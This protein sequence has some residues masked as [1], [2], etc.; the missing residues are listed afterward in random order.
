MLAQRHGAPPPRGR[1]RRRPAAGS[2][3]RRAGDRDDSLTLLF[4]CCHPALTPVSQIALTLR[5]VGGLTTAEIARALLVPEST[6]GAAHQP[7]QGDGSARAA[8]GSRMPAAGERAARLAAVL[9]VLYLVFNEG[10]TAS[11]GGRRC[12]GPS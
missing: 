6:V 10:Y 11:S 5:A 8:P 9:H 12:T 7:G 3:P 4:L 2:T 1:R